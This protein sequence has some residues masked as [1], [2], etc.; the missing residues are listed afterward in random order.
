MCIPFIVP[1]GIVR[2]SFLACQEAEDTVLKIRPACFFGRI[3]L[4]FTKLLF[5]GIVMTAQSESYRLGFY[6]YL[7][8]L[9]QLQVAKR[10]LDPN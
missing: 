6:W 9:V 1:I 5:T 10:N 3:W 7:L 8:V 4:A 2:D